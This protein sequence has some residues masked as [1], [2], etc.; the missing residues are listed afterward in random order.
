MTGGGELGFGRAVVE[1]RPGGAPRIARVEN[2]VGLG[3]VEGFDESARQ[4]EDDGAV[5]P[6]AHFGD[7][8]AHLRRLA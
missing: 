4:I 7:Q 6:A 2:D 1:Q 5:L 8:L 3:I